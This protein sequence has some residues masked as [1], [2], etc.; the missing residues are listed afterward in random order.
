MQVLPRRD[1]QTT[2]L[3]NTAMADWVVRNGGFLQ[4]DRAIF[5]HCLGGADRLIHPPAHVGV[6]HQGKIGA[7]K[8]AHGSD[9][10]QVLAQIVAP[11]LHLDSLEALVQIVPGLGE[12]LIQWEEQI[13]AAGIGQDICVM[14]A[15]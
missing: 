4:P 6:H 10:L 8:V 9:P 13:D 3:G 15:Q 14:A 2:H 7:Q 12:Q 5:G 1:G 11:D